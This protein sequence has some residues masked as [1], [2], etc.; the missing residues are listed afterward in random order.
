MAAVTRTD[1]GGP[2]YARI[3]RAL[4]GLLGACRTGR[5]SRQ[6]VSV[7]EVLLPMS[8]AWVQGGQ[9]ASPG[10]RD[11]LDILMDGLRAGA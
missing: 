5:R 3:C 10:R 9:C 1:A 7:H 2:A 4:E 8:Y 11:V 6:D